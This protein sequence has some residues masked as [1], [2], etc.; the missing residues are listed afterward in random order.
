MALPT[1]CARRGFVNALYNGRVLSVHDSKKGSVTVVTYKVELSRRTERGMYDLS[2]HEATRTHR[3]GFVLPSQNEWVKAAYYDRHGGGT[4]SYWKY[5]TNPGVFGDGGA[6]APSSTVLNPSNGNVT[7][8]STQPLATYQAT[9]SPAPTW[10][11]AEVKPTV[12]CS[13]VNPLG[14]DPGHLRRQLSRFTQ[15]CR[16]GEDA[17]A[18]GHARPGWQRG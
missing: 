6:T 8:A 2:R 7:N 13:T 1:S 14:L 4:F 15:H 16:S 18:M 12:K 10:C 11:P 9:D 3:S 17:L 5:P